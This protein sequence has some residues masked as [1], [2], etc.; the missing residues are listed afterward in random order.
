MC[1]RSRRV[2]AGATIYSLNNNEL[3]GI[4]NGIN[5]L[6]TIDI[7][8]L[9]DKYGNAGFKFVANWDGS[10]S[11]FLFN[12][13]IGYVK[14]QSLSIITP[15]EKKAY[16]VGESFDKTGM[17]VNG[18]YSDGSEVQVTDYTISPSGALS[19]SNS[20]VTIKKDNISVRQN[21]EVDRQ[22]VKCLIYSEERSRTSEDKAWGSWQ[23]LPSSNCVV[24]SGPLNQWHSSIKIDKSQIDVG[25]DEKIGLLLGMYVRDGLTGSHRAKHIRINGARVA[26]NSMSKTQYF[27][28]GEV[29]KGDTGN[30]EVMFE[31]DDGYLEF[32]FN[33]NEP[34]VYFVKNSDPTIKKETKTF[35]LAEGEMRINMA[36][37][38]P[39]YELVDIEA[40]STPLGIKISHVISPDEGND[41]YGDIV[42]MNL[43]ERLNVD[44]VDYN[45]YVKTHI[46]TDGYGNKHILNVL[47]Y[48]ISDGT[49][50]Y[51]SE[52]LIE[53]IEVQKIGDLVLGFF[54]EGH[55]V[56]IDYLT[57]DCQV[58]TKDISSSISENAYYKNVLSDAVNLPVNWL[59]CDNIMKGFNADGDLVLIIDEFC[60]YTAIR[61]GSEGK[62]N[63]IED[64]H[65]NYISFNYDS[66]G[67]LSY[68]DYP[69]NRRVR[70]TYVQINMSGLPERN[71]LNKVEYCKIENDGTVTDVYKTVNLNYCKITNRRL[72]AYS[73]SSVTSSDK[74]NSTILYESE[75]SQSMVKKI[76]TRST[77]NYIPDGT[78]TG[79]ILAEFQFSYDYNKS[80]TTIIDNYDNQY[81]YK[82]G[83]DGNLSDY[84]EIKNGKVSEYR[85]HEYTI[86][87]QN[88]VKNAK[89]SLLNKKPLSS[90][91]FAEGNSETDLLN[92]FNKI[93][94]STVIEYTDNAKIKTYTVY[95]YDD[96][97]QCNEEAITT[98]YSD[99]TN[100][101]LLHKEKT[102]TDY[103]YD[104]TKR[105][106]LKKITHSMHYDG[107]NEVKDK[108]YVTEYSYNSQGYLAD[109]I[110]YNGSW[111][112][113][114][115]SGTCTCNFSNS[116]KFHF[117]YV[118]DSSGRIMQSKTQDG[119]YY[120]AYE[121][122]EG[123][124]NLKSISRQG[125]SDTFYA[126]NNENCLTKVSATDGGLENCA[127]TEYSLGEKVELNHSGN[128][129]IEFEYDGKR[130]V[131][132]IKLDGSD[133]LN[134]TY[135]EK[136]QD[137]TSIVDKVTSVNAN[138]ETMVA[139][140]DRAGSFDK[141][142]YNSQL[143]LQHNYNAS[144]YL[145]STQDNLAGI[146][147]TF[148]IGTYGNLNS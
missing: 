51:L 45:E 10:D 129:P 55:K 50:R 116:D 142:F 62:I 39:I 3:V 104:S 82:F 97:Y 109:Q 46:Y 53:N 88:V 36:N 118:Y 33:N 96:T 85:K 87:S 24:L 98:E 14:L 133:Y 49:R 68:I 79:D 58:Y 71:Q 136:V 117:Q 57:P 40:D 105:I 130:R 26:L 89:R 93:T 43:N 100:S 32:G 2:H 65:G 31:Y 52:S 113:H 63:T 77:Q 16:K 70:Y 78:T 22:N 135:E 76:T 95:S 23:P 25:N 119:L 13:S 141:L 83:V 134:F 8:S 120:D 137:G 144:G 123:T 146:T 106:L 4:N 59:R 72:P 94:T 124:L 64:K 103:I 121:Y 125:R 73:L 11:V 81:N 132:K 54:F 131:S 38:M 1:A 47:F 115:Y 145:T 56:Y 114:N 91:V 86:Y 126:Y 20:Y 37:G 6:Y 34:T 127:I 28:I 27:Y 29:K 108:S 147:E 74:L 60:N 140:A 139:V 42:N 17:V 111:T 102:V 122:Y 128:R 15:P 99:L 138:S 66:N 35:S 41:L 143:I 30:L 110:T 112:T 101:S 84:Y 80:L 18:K 61:R 69:G 107:E 148:S 19:R 90:F 9:Y 44:A 7:K 5:N 67:R 75:D 21:I 48:Y 12:L 92:F